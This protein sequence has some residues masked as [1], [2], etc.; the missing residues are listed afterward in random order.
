MTKLLQC[1][2]VFTI[3]IFNQ[4]QAG[5]VSPAGC[6]EGNCFN[7]YGKYQYANGNRY[8]G[9][10]AEGRPNGNGILYCSNGNKYLGHWEDSYRQGRGKFLFRE[11]HVYVGQFRRNMFHGEGTMSY[12]NGDRYEGRWEG[13]LPNGQGKYFFKKGGRYEGGFR[14]GRFHG[15]GTMFYKNGSRFVGNWWQSKKHGPGIFYNKDGTAQRGEWKYGRPLDQNIQAPEEDE[16]MQVGQTD[17]GEASPPA[18]DII[19]QKNGSPLAPAEASS[20]RIWAVVVGVASYDH[21][22]SLRYTDDDAYQFYAFLK[23]P[24]GGALPDEQVK[25]L[26]DDNA[27]KENILSAMK[28]T[29]LR[30]D[31][32]DVLLFYFSGHGVKG[33]FIPVDFDGFDNRLYHTEIRQIL[34]RSRARYKVV[35][36]DACNSG[37]LYGNSLDDSD[38]MASRNGVGNML[39]Q[40]YTAF[41]DSDGGLALLMSSKGREVSLEDSG[42]RSGV[43]SHFLIQGLKGAADFDHN[44]IIT[45]EEAYRFTNEKVSDYTAGAQTPV[46]KGN[47]DSNMPVGVVRRR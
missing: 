40:Y 33:A 8:V 11:G 4:L 32:N 9:D 27:T 16:T 7:G 24:E 38:L 1:A 34:D 23:S 3:L 15:E 36:G 2:V 6:Q 20:I 22:P 37:T 19:E 29:L 25:V 30:A 41:E 17:A 13:N 26:V 31:E 44:N 21:M 45:I 18:V 14:Q 10:F 39:N 42:L 47:Y 28:N 46:L 12:A 43:F 5:N 35:V